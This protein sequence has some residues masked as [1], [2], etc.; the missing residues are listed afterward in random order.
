M[1][2]EKNV[3]GLDLGN[4]YAKIKSD[5]TLDELILSWR[6]VS[7]SDYNA[8][9]SVE[10]MEKVKYKDQ[11]YIV[12]KTG[13]KGINNRNKGHESVRDMANMIKLTM[14]AR[15]MREIGVNEKEFHVVSGTPYDDFEKNYNDYIKLFKG[16]H[17]TEEIE[18]D[19]ETYKISVAGTEITKQGACV[20]L[21]I[22]DRKEKNYLILDWGGET[23]DVSLF[24]KGIRIKGL[25]IGF[26]LNR[27]YVDLAKDLN[28]YMDIKRPSLN[29]AI[30]MNDME[31]L[32]LE[33]HYRGVHVI[34]VNGETITLKKYVEEW[35]QKQVDDVISQVINEL[36]LNTS[37]L[38]DLI[39]VNIGG[40]SKLL[41]NE[42]GKN[43]QLPSKSMGEHAEYR[44][45]IAYH[46]IGKAL[47]TWK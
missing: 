36:D 14:L 5:S 42:L 8:T 23:L 1:S 15:E 43:K 38:N 4:R 47:T 41:E 10:G 9:E 44:N 6:E 29:D 39:S 13:T 25:T 3:V 34:E 16:D 35:F 26:A 24:E 12:G 17:E 45:V 11:Y 32:K 7:E 27:L 21:T 46:S 2:N 22:K 40:G 20:I 28:K 33:G 19:G 30:F 18:L 37:D 31:T